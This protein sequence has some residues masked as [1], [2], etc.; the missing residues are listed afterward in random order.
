[1]L[2]EQSWAMPNT[3]DTFNTG[4]RLDYDSAPRLEGLCRGEL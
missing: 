1:M 3:F 2:G 4:A